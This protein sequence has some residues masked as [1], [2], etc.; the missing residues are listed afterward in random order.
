MAKIFIFRAQAALDLRQREHDARRRALATARWDLL[1][2][3]RTLADDVRAVAE[4]RQQA[5]EALQRAY[6]PATM[7][8]HERWIVRLERTQAAHAAVVTQRAA[9]VEQAAA[10]CEIARQRLDAME[11]LRAKAWQAWLE[12]ERKQEQRELDAFA[13]LRHAH[14]A[15]A[16]L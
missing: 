14:A 7:P 9:A 4:A 16:G 15:R 8:W 13:T 2:A 12:A 6:D 5:D 10:A 11:R 1:A 3:E